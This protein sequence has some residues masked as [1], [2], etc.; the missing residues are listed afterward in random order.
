MTH[1]TAT[2]AFL[3]LLFVAK[4]SP[5]S[6]TPLPRRK[7]QVAER[8]AGREA[9]YVLTEAEETTEDGLS[10]IILS[11]LAVRAATAAARTEE[12]R[13]KAGG[14]CVRHHLGGRL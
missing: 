2:C 4:P 1:P 5:T 11:R 7:T 9:P 14:K 6:T 12:A 13:R 8:V 10:P 3:F